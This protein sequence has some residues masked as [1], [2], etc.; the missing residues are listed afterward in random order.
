M[1][2]KKWIPAALSTALVATALAACT[3]GDS[4][5]SDTERVLRIASTTLGGDDG[6]WF[7]Q[8]FTEI[9]E[10]AHKNIKLEFV[11]VV[12]ESIMYGPVKE[13]EE[14]PD[15]LVKLKEVMQGPNPPDVVMVDLPQMKELISE[16]LLKPLD[17]L[18][19]KDKFDTSGI[20]PSVMEGLS[21]VSGDGKLYALA[22]LFSSSAIVYNKKI[23][24]DA[25]VE[26]PSDEMTWDQLFDLARRVSGG[27][28]ENQKWGFNFQ[29]QGYSD[30]FESSF[31]YTAPLGLEYFSEDKKSLAVDS[32]QW[33]AVWTKLIQLSK[34]KVMPS[35]DPNDPSTQMRFRGNG[36][37]PFS[38]DDFMS[39]RLAMTIM[40]YG[41]LS[42]I[43]NANKNA[44]NLTGYTP[45]EYDVAAL[46]THPENP[47]VAAG[48]TLYGIM[49][50]NSKAGN[51]ADAWR[52]LKFINGEDWARA[53]SNNNYQLVSHKKYIKQPANNLNM[54]A[55]FKNK[56]LTEGQTEMYWIY[57]QRNPNLIQAYTLGRQELMSAIRGEKSV[58]EA[59]AA[60]KTQG[61]QLLSQP[62]NSGGSGGA[63]IAVP[64]G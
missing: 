17:P 62:V 36:Q 38:Y 18:I 54:E 61:D 41:Q 39:G 19:A 30:I 34:D 63:A 4:A 64:A 27:E 33:E 13:G 59:L 10:Y 55:F 26:F 45:I 51:E 20:L 44:A 53:K 12:D 48:L 8:Q 25:G 7:R 40:N 35:L 49:G 46:P 5:D 9:F 16:N 11:P 37:N 23:F 28:G 50:I 24:M 22:P 43:D 6:S 1:N 15:P 31:M 52:F 60:W 56:P 32:E 14:R 57:Q 58:K 29:S 47:G 42:Q 21:S 2:M 3:D